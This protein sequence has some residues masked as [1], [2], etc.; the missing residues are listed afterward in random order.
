MGMDD[1]IVY[2]EDEEQRLANLI[3]AMKNCESIQYFMEFLAYAMDSRI[4][5]DS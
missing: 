1:P 5:T 2:A 3:V 4:N